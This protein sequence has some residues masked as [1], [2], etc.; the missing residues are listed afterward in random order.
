MEKKN[1]SFPL[2]V[3]ATEQTQADSA[4]LS[5]LTLMQP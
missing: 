1:H 4:C 3:E 2:Q 5:N